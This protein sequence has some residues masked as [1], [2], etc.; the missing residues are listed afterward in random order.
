MPAATKK[1]T[2]FLNKLAN[3]SVGGVLQLDPSKRQAPP[4]EPPPPASPPPQRREPPPAAP[5]ESPAARQP[6]PPQA[7]PQKPQEPPAAKPDDEPVVKMRSLPG[8][9]P[10][11]PPVKPDFDEEA[12]NRTTEESSQGMDPKA[13]AKFHELRD[14]LKKYITGADMPG[15]V[16]TRIEEIESKAK[17][18]EELVK[19]NEVLKQRV[20][21]LAG[22]SARAM[23]EASDLYEHSVLKP[24][25][26][27]EGTMKQ[28][29]E[30]SKVDVEDLKKV[31]REGDPA[32]QDTMIDRLR[33]KI[34]ASNSRRLERCCDDWREIDAIQE[35]MLSDAENVLADENKRRSELRG[36][37]IREN[38]NSIREHG[39]RW[40]NEYL[41]D[42]PGFTNEDGSASEIAKRVVGKLRASDPASMNYE[43]EGFALYAGYALEEVV[44]LLAKERKARVKLEDEINRRESGRPKPSDGNMGRTPAAPAGKP[45][46]LLEHMRTHKF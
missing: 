22:T 46:G 14:E 2:G 35:R 6:E 1:P 24:R 43:D 20:A 7:P 18:A 23:V 33:D 4:A 32:K 25:D 13:K 17:Q 40:H 44:N 38:A 29:A 3:D 28:I 9:E 5:P 11:T 41:K 8:V 10:E 45:M 16:K 36:Q 12:F 34:G 19:E 27:V 42:V 26:A 15:S 21:K 37:K 31:V 39:M 30:L